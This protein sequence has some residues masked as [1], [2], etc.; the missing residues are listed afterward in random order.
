MPKGGARIGAGRK[1]GGQNKSNAAIKAIIDA[2][3][4][5]NVVIRRLMEL[6]MEG[7]VNAGKL[8]LEYRFG[9][10]TQAVDVTSGGET[11]TLP[12]WI[13]ETDEDKPES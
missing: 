5:F 7:D 3:I 13:T 2:Q 4:D 11:I 12:S 8:L 1:A 6:F 9:R 10:P